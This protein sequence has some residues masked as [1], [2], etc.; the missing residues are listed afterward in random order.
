MEEDEGGGE[1]G[2]GEEV[3]E[4]VEIG[5]EAGG[6][7]EFAG[8]QTVDGVE[9]HAEEEEAGEEEVP[10]G[11]EDRGPDG[12]GGEGGEDGNLVGG[13]A[14]AEQGGGEGPEQLLELWLQ[15]VETRQCFRFYT[16][17]STMGAC[18]IGLSLST[19]FAE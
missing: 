9:G 8:E 17:D 2:V 19:F 18:N 3:A 5:T 6:L 14:E 7:A 15:G 11:G 12:A 10:T 1:G 16:S 13:D 4:F